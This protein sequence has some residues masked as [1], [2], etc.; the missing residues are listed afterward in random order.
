[1]VI[2]I[3]ILFRY[4]EGFLDNGYDDLETV[5]K[6]GEVDL[7]MVGVTQVFKKVLGT[8]PR[9]ASQVANFKMCNFPSEN[10]QK[11]KLD[12]FRRRRLQ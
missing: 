12:L 1:M 3:L 6:M 11:V 2:M 10:F 4:S 8:F 7:L 9:A 5:K